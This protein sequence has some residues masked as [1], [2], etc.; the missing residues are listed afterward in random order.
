MSVLYSDFH[1]NTNIG[2]TSNR[3]GNAWRLCLRHRGLGGGFTSRHGRKI[4]SGNEHV[5]VGRQPQDRR[6]VSGCGGLQRWAAGIN[7]IKFVYPPPFPP[8]WLLL[9]SPMLMDLHLNQ[10]QWG[11]Q[12]SSMIPQQEVIRPKIRFNL[13][14]PRSLRWMMGGRG[15]V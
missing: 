12:A 8:K 5:V 10:L 9:G 13:L 4:Q 2:Y 6:H 3:F 14:C 1:L 15:E 11:L 7:I